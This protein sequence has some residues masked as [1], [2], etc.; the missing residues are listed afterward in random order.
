MKI[1]VLILDT[2][3]DTYTYIK[4]ILDNNEFEIKNGT[5]AEEG[6]L[7]LNKF[8]ADIVL[9]DVNLPDKQNLNFPKRVRENPN[10]FLNSMYIIGMSSKS[11]EQN[12]AKVK[13]LN[14]GAHDF[15]KK[16][17]SEDE[18]LAKID[19][20][21][22]LSKKLK[23]AEIEFH[24]MFQNMDV[25][26]IQDGG[27]APGYNPI[28]AY[29]TNFLEQSG[30]NVYCT[31]EGYKSI[32]AGND[33]DY[34]RLIY[35]ST[36]YKKHEHIR[37][38]FNVSLLSEARG[39]QFRSERF[40]EFSNVDIQ[41][42][43]ASEIL[44][45]NIKAIVAIGG[46]GTFMGIHSLARFLPESINLFF[47][48]VTIDSDVSGTE[49][50]GEHTGV[51]M[52]AEK[53]RCY[54][55]DARTHKRVYIIEM[56]G[57]HGGFHALHSCIGARAHLAALPGIEVDFA[58]VV[59][60]LNEK[61]S[62]VIVVAEGFQVDERKNENIKGNAAKYFHQR[63]T[64]TKIPIKPKIVCESFSRDIRGAQPNN[65]DITLAQRMALIVSTN[66]CQNQTKIMP[67]IQG[68]LE[69]VVKFE[70]IQTENTVNP[71]LLKIANR[72]Y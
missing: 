23:Q 54:M 67:S 38:V 9:V 71:S 22:R 6:F 19:V 8:K 50:I 61:E 72:L 53:I 25:L 63:L 45:R 56:M 21:K 43:A 66:L 17:F 48:P 31:K 1:N 7:I 13:A 10:H 24:D 39:A 34:V 52:G 46:N 51:E 70:D 26:L 47:I 30:R 37:N 15:I 59:H 40:P 28:T 57:A 5:S 4:K 60:A 41:K 62:A 49:T 32:V 29:L 44:K 33:S 68:G 64:E 27:C 35:N 2:S 14:K 3:L 16:P 11:G 36:E 42:K 12:E 18:L 69:G 65:L 58:K 20:G 55:A